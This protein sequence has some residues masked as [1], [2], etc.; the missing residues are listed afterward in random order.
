MLNFGFYCLVA[1]WPVLW[2]PVPGAI[3]LLMQMLH[4]HLLMQ[5]LHLLMQMLH[6]LMQEEKLLAD[7]ISLDALT[8]IYVI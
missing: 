3:S 6:L 4:H 2:D 1:G 5:M 8:K 7:L